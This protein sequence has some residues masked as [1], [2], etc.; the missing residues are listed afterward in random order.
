MTAAL[1]PVRLH[2]RSLG[3]TGDEPARRAAVAERIDNH[4]RGVIPARGQLPPQERTK[5]FAQMVEAANGTAALLPSAADVPAAVADFL[6]AHNLPMQVRRGDDSRL[7]ALP[8]EGSAR[9]RSRP[10][11]RMAISLSRLPTRS[12]ASPRPGRW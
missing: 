3:V 1:H 6:R 5:L 10:A 9:S 7:A 8:W 11:P 4:P 2:P 12:G